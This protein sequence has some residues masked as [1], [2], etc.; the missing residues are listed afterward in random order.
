MAWRHA[1]VHGSRYWSRYAMSA[2]MR[3]IT[4]SVEQ[5][6]LFLIALNS[7]NSRNSFRGIEKKFASRVFEKVVQTMYHRNMERQFSSLNCRL[8]TSALMPKCLD[9]SDP[10]HQC[11]GVLSPKC[12][13]AMQ[14]LTDL[15]EHSHMYVC[16]K[17][18]TVS[19]NV[20]KSWCR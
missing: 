7:W 5:R 2:G 1:C 17:C 6:V 15:A 8:D 13:Q 18:F 3:S 10:P 9:S 4:A 12:P 14:Q 16:K 11:W 19:E 20:D